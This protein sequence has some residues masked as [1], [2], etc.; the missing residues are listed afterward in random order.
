M[1]LIIAALASA[2]RVHAQELDG[3]MQRV[4]GAW[5]RNDEKSIAALIARDGASIE[6]RGD[7][8]GP[9]GARQAAAVLRDVF[10]DHITREVQTRQTQT[11]GGAPQKGYGE[12][13]WMT[14]APETTE[15]VRIVVFVEFVL[16]QEKHWRITK[17]RLL[18]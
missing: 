18:P 15:P 3:V 14:M 17:I 7:R 16:E 11:V 5:S 2:S 12:L 9:L 6:R 13:I 8:M 4:A 10:S 1:L